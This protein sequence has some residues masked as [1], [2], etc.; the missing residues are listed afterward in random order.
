MMIGSWLLNGRILYKGEYM[1]EKE[2]LQ[3]I[4]NP[5][6]PYLKSKE[7]WQYL[8]VSETEFYTRIVKEP[9]FPKPIRLGKKLVLYEKSE[10][11]AFMKR[12]KD[13]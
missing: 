8:N 11:D 1:Q 9:D 4:V 6:S 10:L 12:R 3:G 13:A 7:A 5:K 2:K